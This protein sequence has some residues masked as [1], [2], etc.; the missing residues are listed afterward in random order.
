M[1]T[2]RQALEAE[3][4]NVALLAIEEGTGTSAVLCRRA[5]QNIRLSTMKNWGGRAR[6]RHWSDIRSS[7]WE[8]LTEL[9]GQRS[10]KPVYQRKYLEGIVCLSSGAYF[11]RVVEPNFPVPECTCYVRE[12]ARHRRRSK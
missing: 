8:V 7:D 12:H 6:P 10:E 5:G 4:A 9:V 1:E 11:L 2:I 3:S